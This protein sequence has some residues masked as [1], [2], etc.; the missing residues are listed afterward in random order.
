MFHSLLAILLIVH[1]VVHFTGL[2][3]AFLPSFVPSFTTYINKPTG[4]DW[5]LAGSFFILAGV[6]LLVSNEYWW[7]V[8]GTA[9]LISQILIVFNWHDARF[10]TVVNVILFI[11]VFAGAS[12]WNFRTRY[13]EAADRTI[14]HTRT[15]SAQRIFAEDLAPLPRPVQRYL[16]AAGVVGTVRPRSMRITFDGSIRGFE[17]PWMPFTS[18]QTNSFDDPARFFWIDATMKG[19]PTKG[20]HA[21]ENGKAT[22]LI[23]VLGVVPVMEAHGPEMDQAET[24][25]WFNDLCIYAPGAL[26]DPR[27]SWTELDDRSSKATFTNGAQRISATLVFNAEDQ[28]IDFF[29]DDRYAITDGNAEPLRFS[30]PLRDHRP[31]HG[32]VVPGYGEAV[33]HRPEGP[34]VYG[35]F[36]LR[37]LDHDV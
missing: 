36:T 19:L 24:V 35:R 4:L 8:T 17:G 6:L 12:V 15:L 3:R 25:T 7:M 31:M 27:I 22:M 20:L 37:S 34:F 16:Q 32:L 2:I 9:I 26:L 23:K 10:G 11:A 30:T 13:T 14:E 5:A 21:Y 33:W 29:S 18:V 1:G 28:L